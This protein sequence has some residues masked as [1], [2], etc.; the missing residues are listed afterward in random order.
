MLLTVAL[1]G[2]SAPMTW[3][4]HQLTPIPSG[5]GQSGL[6]AMRSEAI[7]DILLLR[8]DTK[9]SQESLKQDDFSTDVNREYRLADERLYRTADGNF[10]IGILEYENTGVN[11]SSQ[12]NMVI[13][14]VEDGGR[15][16]HVAQEPADRVMDL[17]QLWSCGAGQFLLV[18]YSGPWFSQSAPSH[19]VIYQL[20]DPVAKA[21]EVASIFVPERH[22]SQQPVVVASTN[23][24]LLSICV[25]DTGIPD[26][27]D[28]M[29]QM[30]AKC[31][32]S[33]CVVHQQTLN[34]MWVK[35][36]AP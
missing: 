15:I 12:R 20:G 30:E 33:S 17:P 6:A 34:E 9:T 28:R 1:C 21:P 36:R 31:F 10:T 7:A 5:N 26:P 2:C 29:D 4:N 16:V 18:T 24:S 3:T 32:G 13:V 8:A 35:I 27:A 19:I 22:A 14:L 11:H 25:R 23:A